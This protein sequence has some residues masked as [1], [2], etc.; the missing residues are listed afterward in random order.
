MTR[1]IVDSEKA[2]FLSTLATPL[3]PWVGKSPKKWLAKIGYKSPIVER[4]AISPTRSELYAL[5]GSPTV[6]AQDCAWVTMAWGGMRAD[7][8]RMLKDS[9]LGWINVCEQIRDGTLSRYEA[10]NAFVQL[11]KTKKLRGAGPAYF[12]KLIHFARKEAKGYILDQWTARSVHVLTNQ[13]EWPKTAISAGRA[14][15]DHARALRVRVDDS[16]SASD[17]EAYCVW[18]DDLATS[19]LGD[20]CDGASM[21]EWLFSSGGKPPHPWREYVMTSWKTRNPEFYRKSK[22]PST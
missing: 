18:V 21:E 12:T 2:V 4:L 20:S 9:G 8:G 11:K 17:Y 15:K 3:R 10:Y 13:D 1:E 5:W 14:T 16:V 6:S 19:G 22:K 7:H